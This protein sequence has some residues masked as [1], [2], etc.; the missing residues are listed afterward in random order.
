MT[1]YGQAIDSIVNGEVSDTELKI[2]T[3]GGDIDQMSLEPMIPEV[4]IGED[5][6]ISS[7]DTIVNL[8]TTRPTST[9]SDSEESKEEISSL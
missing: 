4:K 6:M 2:S 9:D 8:H 7:N 5:G 3:A 1:G